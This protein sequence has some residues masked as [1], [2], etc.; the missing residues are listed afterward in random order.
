MLFG[1]FLGEFFEQPCFSAEG[2]IERNLPVVIEIEDLLLVLA[3]V[4]NWPRSDGHGGI[5]AAE[6][7]AVRHVMVI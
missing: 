2:F 1:L 6:T 4:R 7:V 5:L 3:V